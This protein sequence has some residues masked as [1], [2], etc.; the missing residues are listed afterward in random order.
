MKSLYESLLDD[1]EDLGAAQDK[2]NKEGPLAQSNWRIGKDDKTIIYSPEKNNCYWGDVA[3]SPSLC[4]GLRTIGDNLNYKSLSVC[5]DFGLKFQPLT[6]IHDNS[7]VPA[8]YWLDNLDC[9]SVISVNVNLGNKDRVL[10]FSKVKFDIIGMIR[11]MGG[12]SIDVDKIIPYK[13]PLETVAFCNFLPAQTISGWNCKNLIVYQT[14]IQGELFGVSMGTDE[15]FANHINEILK[16]NP[17]VDT[18]YIKGKINGVNYK[19]VTKGRKD[20]RRM[21]TIK[22]VSSKT[23]LSLNHPADNTVMWKAL[24]DVDSWRWKHDELFE[25]DCAP[26]V[27]GAATPGNT[28]GMGNPMAPTATEPGTEPLVANVKKKKRDKNKK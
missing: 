25:C 28:M 14:L 27:A 3:P 26:A 9:D 10:D 11:F 24:N 4:L 2:S 8:Q 7:E 6:S 20:K 18:L 16:N 13:Y 19:V 1:I 15:K 22:K 12:L 17:D 21:D 5:K 23:W